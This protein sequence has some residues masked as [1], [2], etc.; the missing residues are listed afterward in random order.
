MAFRE[1]NVVH[2]FVLTFAK[3]EYQEIFRFVN[4]KKLTQPRHEFTSSRT[5]YLRCLTSIF[6]EVQRTPFNLHDWELAHV[7]PH[8]YWCSVVIVKHPQRLNI[9]NTYA[10]DPQLKPTSKYLLSLIEI[11]VGAPKSSVFSLAGTLLTRLL[12]RNND[13][14]VEK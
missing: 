11:A 12:H 1:L 9:Q 10:T 13:S 8:C 7:V 14:E 3:V 5:A 6:I 2:G 4:H